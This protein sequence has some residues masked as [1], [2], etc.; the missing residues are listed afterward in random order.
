MSQDLRKSSG[1]TR[2]NVE[3]TMLRPEVGCGRHIA[4][5]KPVGNY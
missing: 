3:V 1:L 5:P 4:G 2:F